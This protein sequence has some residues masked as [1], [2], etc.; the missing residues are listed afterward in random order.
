MSA[1]KC[2]EGF[3]PRG[4]LEGRLWFPVKKVRV[5]SGGDADVAKVTE[6][7]AGEG[8][9]AFEEVG[10]DESVVGAVAVKDDGSLL[11]A[12]AW[13]VVF[14]DDGVFSSCE[15]ADG[16]W[17]VDVFG[18]V[19]GAERAEGARFARGV[20]GLVAFATPGIVEFSV[21]EEFL[22]DEGFWENEDFLGDTGIFMEVEEV[23]WEG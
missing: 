5:Q 9:G 6:G 4:G 1:S 22:R 14:T 13:W 23:E 18:S 16:G 7:S 15:S 11:R 20:F 2:G 17:P 8:E 3:I 12:Q 19:T 21:G 10:A